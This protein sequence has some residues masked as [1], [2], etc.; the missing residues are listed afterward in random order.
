VVIQ[1]K[2]PGG[3][4]D[5]LTK[6]LLCGLSA[7]FFCEQGFPPALMV[8]VYAPN[9]TNQLMFNSMLLGPCLVHPEN[10][11]VFKISRHIESYG[12][13]MKH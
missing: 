3:S 7:F 6:P 5:V 8:S 13:Y 11:K 12:T 1:E 10:Q 9:T 4:C 2:E